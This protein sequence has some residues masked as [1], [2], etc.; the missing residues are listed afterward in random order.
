MF[1]PSPTS[2]DPLSWRQAWEAAAFGESGFYRRVDCRPAD[3]FR[4]SAHVGGPFVHAIFDRLRAVDERLAH[5][6][7]LTVVDVGAGGAEL[8]N[9]LADLI[10]VDD[11][12]LAGRVELIGVD[13]RDRPKQLSAD[14]G[15]ISELAPDGV[16]TDITGVIIA[17]ELLD[18]IPLDI[19]E[20]D[21]TGDWRYVRLDGT[22]AV[23][24][25][26]VLTSADHEWVETFASQD[27]L[28]GTP[29][30]QV[31][32]GSTRDAVGSELANRL[33]DGEALFIDYVSGLESSVS[34]FLHGHQIEPVADGSMNLTA[35]VNQHSLTATLRQFGDVEVQSQA[36]ALADFRHPREG[37]GITMMDRLHWRSSWQELTDRSGLGRHSWISLTRAREQPVHQD[38]QQEN[39][40]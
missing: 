11:P 4:T 32:I 27:D 33:V 24:L 10:R 8:L 31:E 18:D 14:I 16:P 26:E 29:R 30:A 13:M 28:P 12:A 36:A 1:A 17:T 38:T 35:A 25:G 23:S 21:A 6:P 22:R 3:H 5:P 19:A 7:T 37:S 40:R 9:A 39:D 15:W 2:A 20:R 34:A